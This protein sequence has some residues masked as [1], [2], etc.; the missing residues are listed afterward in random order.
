M[1]DINMQLHPF[2]SYIYIYFYSINTDSMAKSDHHTYG[3]TNSWIKRQNMVYV[4]FACV[5]QDN[6][7]NIIQGPP[8]CT[9]FDAIIMEHAQHDPLCYTGSGS[10]IRY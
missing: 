5:S 9:L 10:S 4:N 3:F 7:R 6:C 1:N 8:F 2:V